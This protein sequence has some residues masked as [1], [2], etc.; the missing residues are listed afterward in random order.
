MTA[1]C[2]LVCFFGSAIFLPL[3]LLSFGKIKNP[4]AF[5]PWIWQ[6]LMCLFIY[7]MI[8]GIKIEIHGNVEPSD[9]FAVILSN[10]GQGKVM[11]LH[12]WF[13][14]R[15]IKR[16]QI[17]FQK[18]ENLLNPFVGLPMWI[19]RLSIF[20]DRSNKKKAQRSIRRGIR[21][22]AG[23]HGAVSIHPDG[24]RPTKAKLDKCA[25]DF[26]G[27]L[28]PTTWMKHSLLW[29]AGG[30]HT[31]L[32]TL[33]ALDYP[34]RVFVYAHGFDRPVSNIS[35]MVGATFHIH[36]REEINFPDNEEDVRKRMLKLCKWVNYSI[37]AWQNMR[38]FETPVS[39]SA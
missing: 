25:A 15:Y 14:S 13:G 21:S 12:H 38:T 17:V 9:E 23:R 22:L 29:R 1:I 5:I 37:T 26:R 4:F 36:V 10:H 32:K 2:A 30:T 35:D 24:T 28:G 33:R 3:V 31:T 19:G 27:D 11:P 20:F 8:L 34:F 7:R 6:E 16:R 39:R 18:R